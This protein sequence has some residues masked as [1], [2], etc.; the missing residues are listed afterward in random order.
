MKSTLPLP[1]YRYHPTYM[2]TRAT[3]PDP[4]SGWQPH[5]ATITQ[6]YRE[7][8]RPLREVMLIMESEHGFKAT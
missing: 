6:L 8:D 5:K 7:E 2:M 3:Y 1:G 4:A